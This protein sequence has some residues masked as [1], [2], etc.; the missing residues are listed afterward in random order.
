MIRWYRFDTQYFTKYDKSDK[1]PD[2]LI[3]AGTNNGVYVKNINSIF[4]FF[5]EGGGEQ[6]IKSLSWN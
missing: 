4:L 5:L 3:I 6:W 2:I 1:I